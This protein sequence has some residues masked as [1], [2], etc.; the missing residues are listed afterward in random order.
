MVSAS[1]S[2]QRGRGYK[3]TS[4]DWGTIKDVMKERNRETKLWVKRKKKS[5]MEK[6]LRRKVGGGESC[7]L[8]GWGR[9]GNTF[10]RESSVFGER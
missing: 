7:R 9:L 4:P 1:S 8:P 3:E 2:K 5:L 10:L 6:A